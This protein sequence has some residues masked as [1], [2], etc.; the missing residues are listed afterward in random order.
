MKTLVLTLA[1]MIPFAFAEAQTQQTQLVVS[2]SFNCDMGP[3]SAH[4]DVIASPEVTATRE[5]KMTNYGGAACSLVS[6]TKTPA[7]VVGDPCPI[8]VTVPTEVAPGEEVTITMV[9]APRAPDQ[10]VEYN[11]DIEWETKVETP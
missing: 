7:C 9:Y 8:T 4:F 2:P 3:S 11:V 6:V 10:I 1:L 5:I